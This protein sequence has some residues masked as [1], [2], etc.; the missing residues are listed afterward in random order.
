MKNYQNEII[1]RDLFNE[2][3]KNEIIK[4]EIIKNEIIKR[5]LSKWNYKN[6]ITVIKFQKINRPFFQNF[7]SFIKEIN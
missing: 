2:I 4:N 6:E 3:I 7:Q 1:K 5:E